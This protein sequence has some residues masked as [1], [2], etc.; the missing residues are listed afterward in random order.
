MCFDLFTSFVCSGCWQYNSNLQRM[1]THCWLAYWNC[2]AASSHNSSTLNF[3][4]TESLTEGQFHCPI[5]PVTPGLHCMR[6]KGKTINVCQLCWSICRREKANCDLVRKLNLRW[7]VNT[8]ICEQ[9]YFGLWSGVGGCKALRESTK[10]WITGTNMFVPCDQPSPVEGGGSCASPGGWRG[11]IGM[12][13][14][15]ARHSAQTE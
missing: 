4:L 5:H 10:E 8:G 1:M 12:W 13:P 2:G 3:I 15:N 6:R 14:R 9:L 7:C 11:E